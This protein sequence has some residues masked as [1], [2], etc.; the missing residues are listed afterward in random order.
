M[1]KEHK[2]PDEPSAPFWM[3]TYAD[4]VTLLFAFFVLLLSFA[5][6]DEV[7]FE[8]AAH[9]LKGALGVLKRHESITNQKH[10]QVTDEEMNRRM[11]IYKSMVALDEMAEDLDMQDN[12]SIEA[13]DRGMLIKMGD[14][15]LFS[16]GEATLKIAASPI[17][18][19]IGKSIKGQA[20]EVL[21]GGHTDNTPIKS[22]RFPSNWELSTARALSVVRYLIDMA[23]VS[24]EIL[25]AVGYGEF[26]PVAP[27]V[28]LE[29]MK[30]NR[31]VEFLVTWK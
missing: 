9:S 18:D 21:I 19:M 1:K 27:N 26:R 25:A 14:Q 5:N 20:G 11:D 17:L 15:V 29:N 4:M 7:K 23:G 16:K 6:M 31:R 13:T 22:V 8:E 12:I 10:I 2:A 28:S 30:K 24:P 3:T